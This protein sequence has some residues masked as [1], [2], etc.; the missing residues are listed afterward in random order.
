LG[1][2]VLERIWAKPAAAINGE[3]ISRADLKAKGTKE[4]GKLDRPGDLY[5]PS[6]SPKEKGNYQLQWVIERGGMEREAKFTFK[7]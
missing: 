6:F 3:S 7:L 4:T 1:S 2:L 5:G